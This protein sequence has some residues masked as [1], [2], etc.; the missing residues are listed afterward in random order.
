[1]IGLTKTL[2]REYA[3]KGVTVNAV[4][5]GFIQTRM[6]EGIPEKAMESSWRRPPLGRLGDP[7]EIAAGVRLPGLALG[8][9]RHR[10]SCST[11]TGDSR[12]KQVPRHP[13]GAGATRSSD[14]SVPSLR[15]P[16]GDRR[17]RD[18]GKGEGPWPIRSKTSPWASSKSGSTRRWPSRRPVYEATLK[19]WSRLFAVP[20]V[21]DR[22]RDVKVGTTPSEIVYEED[23]LRLLRYRRDTPAI[24][25]EPVLI[26]YALVNRPYILDLQP[27]RSVVR[28]FLAKRLRGLPDRLGRPLG[29]R[30][31]HDAQGLRRRAHEELRRRHPQAARGR[32]AST[33]SATAWA[34]RCRPSSPPSI[35]SW[36][37]P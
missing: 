14:R 10:A 15:R 11:S 16:A 3:R 5:P 12:C 36:S 32:R 23:T 20:R 17:H 19:M 31:Q 6:T 22:A 37:R 18:D 13:A 34:A 25:T 2:A 7:V 29:R 35:P 28:Q 26:C 33:S 21:I 9:L 8:G 27:D 4:A 24:Y 1:M 30:P